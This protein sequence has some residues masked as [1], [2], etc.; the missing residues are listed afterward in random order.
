MT[1]ND[2]EAGTF[3]E[4]AAPEGS[5]QKA[6]PEVLAKRR[7][8]KA[9]RTVPTTISDT[10]KPNPFAS[11][12]ANAPPETSPA[13]DSA[14]QDNGNEPGNTQADPVAPPASQMPTAK[15]QLDAKSAESKDAA[16]KG[17]SD[18][19]V[20]APAAEATNADEK[21]D[22][23]LPEPSAEQVKGVAT[24]KEQPADNAV[25]P[26]ESANGSAN[27][28]A[29]ET[30]DVK[31][32]DNQNEDL[33][34][35]QDEKQ[36]EKPEGKEGE[37]QDDKDDGKKDDGNKDDGKKDGEADENAEEKS[38]VN[39]S[40]IAPATTNRASEATAEA[41]SNGKAEEKAGESGGG[42]LKQ[43]SDGKLGG[44][45]DAPSKSESVSAPTAKEDTQDGH[46]KPNGATLSAPISFGTLSGSAPLTFA[47]AAA[48]DGGTFKFTPA[49]VPQPK[50]A[51][52]KEFK[53]AKVETGE[54]DERELFRTRA[55]LYSL[56]NLE[57]KPL[58]KERGVGVL[59]LKFH[60]EKKTAR[61][62]MRTEATLR[63]ILNTPIYAGMKF[64]PATEKSLRFQGFEEDDKEEKKTLTFL[65]RFN[66]RDIASGLVEAVNILES[67][68]EGN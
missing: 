57:S 49:P 68:K 21:Q 12:A 23:K 36:D 58:W 34:E 20:S 64:D 40:E 26:Q 38:G 30:Q 32:N 10:A 55:K 17:A 67:N 27:A 50:P 3:D 41:K 52:Q 59:K 56:E 6:S 53:E 29:V 37:K 31:Q 22:S 13:T 8:L 2:A 16:E 4:E 33:K 51:P 44:T 45:D 39:T 62:L 28:E 46:A 48:S 5:F 42:Q 43:T 61:L 24:D 19:Q 14:A 9:R 66:S 7:M 63:V 18:S 1:K 47:N 11:L 54:E 15:S 65:A 60:K 25:A 35:K